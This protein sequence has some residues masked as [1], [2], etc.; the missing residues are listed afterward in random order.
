ME[1]YELHRGNLV[2]YNDITVKFIT[3]VDD[4]LKKCLVQ[5]P[6]GT[7]KQVQRSKLEF[8]EV[9][10]EFL[11]HNDF[12]PSSNS[13]YADSLFFYKTTLKNDGLQIRCHTSIEGLAMGSVAIT[14]VGNVT[15]ES[16]GDNSVNHFQNIITLAG[17]P[18]IVNK[19]KVKKS[20]SVIDDEEWITF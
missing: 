15:I 3:F 4:K 5:Y 19:M 17:H 13:N 6:D 12:H 18:E 7:T 9:D 2:T 11:L 1:A 16:V 20:Y 10:N 8:I 14:E